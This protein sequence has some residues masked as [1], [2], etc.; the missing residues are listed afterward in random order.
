MLA[1]SQRALFLSA[2]LLCCV[3]IATA[4]YFQYVQGLDPCPLCIMQ[5][6]A[7]IGL[8]AI[9]LLGALHNPGETG[10]RCYGLAM[11]LIAS[12]GG[13]IAGRHVWLQHLPVDQVPSCGPGLKYILETLPLHE[14]FNMILR[15]SGECAETHWSF[16]GLS[17]PGWMLVIFSGFILFGLYLLL[18]PAAEQ[19]AKT[20]S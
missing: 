15:G 11:L 10:R 4:L 7:V 16:L 13:T 19:P 12:I 1:I 6:I 20:L 9:A 2:F 8:G 3:L 14:A 5:R 18:R 17:I